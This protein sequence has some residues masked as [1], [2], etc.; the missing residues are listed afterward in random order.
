GDTLAGGHAMVSATFRFYAQL[1]DFLPAARR[2]RDFTC[3]CARAATAKHMIE[4]LGVPHTEVALILLNGEP[5]DFQRLIRDGDRL[6]VY[7]PFL[8]LDVTPLLGVH[9][10]GPLRFIADVHL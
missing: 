6:A 3:R 2:G 10:A 5:A 9:S 8:S 7:P 4:A 1:N